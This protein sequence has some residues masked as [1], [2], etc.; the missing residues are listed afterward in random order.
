MLALSTPCILAKGV[1]PPL[2]DTEKYHTERPEVI[3]EEQ[4]VTQLAREPPHLWLLIIALKWVRARLVFTLWHLSIN[5]KFCEI[6]PHFSTAG[7]DIREQ[8]HC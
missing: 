6:P 4:S 3:Q 8:A 2:S 1:A 5:I 7:A